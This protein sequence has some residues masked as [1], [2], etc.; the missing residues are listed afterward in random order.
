MFGFVLRSMNYLLL[1]VFFCFA[2]F[3]YCLYYLCIPSFIFQNL[4]HFF[5]VWVKYT[6]VV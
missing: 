4:S 2:F 1:R 3:S 6:A 5:V